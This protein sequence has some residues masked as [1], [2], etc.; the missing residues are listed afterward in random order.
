MYRMRFRRITTILLM[1]VLLAGSGVTRV[2]AAVNEDVKSPAIEAKSAIVYS[3]TTDEVLFTK[4]ADKRVQPWSTTKLMTALI[5]AEE[6]DLDQTVAV[7]SKAASLGG[8]TMN[9][10]AGEKVSVKDLLY[11]LLI[12]S[13]NDAA[14]ALAQAYDGGATK[15][16]ER[17]NARAEELGC[18]GTHFVNPNGLK[19]KNHY[20]TASDF[21]KISK[22]AFANETVYQVGGTKEYHVAKTNKSAART[23]ETHLDLLEDDDSGVVAGKTGYWENNDCSVSLMYDRVGLQLILVQFGAN[24]ETRAEDDELLLKFARKKIVT[25]N[26]TNPDESVG[27]VRVKYGAHTAVD[28]YPKDI[29]L[30]YPKDGSDKSVTFKEHYDKSVE[31]PLKAGDEVGTVDVYCDGKKV[32]TT[33]LL[34]KEDVVKGWFFSRFYISNN[35]TIAIGIILVLLLIIF[36]FLRKRIRGRRDPKG[37]H[38]KA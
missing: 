5:V 35:A 1:T 36:A 6:M 28:S 10:V 25:V 12:E 15:F 11:G 37:K 8:S 9:L 7:S 13:G 3:V 38:W 24:Y 18:T 29:V 33:T 23:L 22:A 16:V 17:M 14:L 27:K 31:A 19:A 20:T 4:N 26:A 32:G 2:L 21:I 30:A 34:V